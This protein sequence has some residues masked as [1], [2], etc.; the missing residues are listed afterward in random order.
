MELGLA[1]LLFSSGSPLT[2]GL[3]SCVGSAP[4]IPLTPDVF[5]ISRLIEKV[6]T[7]VEVGERMIATAHPEV[8]GMLIINIINVCIILHFQNTITGT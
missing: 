2:S 3:P 5:G 6:A 4:L 1:P 8:R 7:E